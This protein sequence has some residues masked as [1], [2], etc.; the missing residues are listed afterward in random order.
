MKY[1]EKGFR[2]LFR[3]NGFE[4]YLMDKFKTSCRCSICEGEE[5]VSKT[6]PD[7]FCISM[8]NFSVGS[9]SLST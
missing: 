7:I 3:R 5:K 8:G 2:D 4:V 1:K 9:A 6:S